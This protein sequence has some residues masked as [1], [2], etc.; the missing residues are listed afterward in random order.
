M[1]LIIEI[2]KEFETDYRNFD[3][4]G[5]FFERVIADID[6]RGACGLYEKEIAQ[7]FEKAFKDAEVVQ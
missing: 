2:P 4:F 6:Y 3:K 1:K 5:N 7:M